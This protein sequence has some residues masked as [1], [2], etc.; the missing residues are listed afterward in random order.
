[1]DGAHLLYERSDASIKAVCG[2][3]GLTY[4]LVEKSDELKWHVWRDEMLPDVSGEP[5][6]CR[7]INHLK[8]VPEELRDD[9]QRTPFAWQVQAGQDT[10]RGTGPLNPGLWRCRPGKAPEKIRDGWYGEIIVTPNGKWAVASRT[11]PESSWATPNPVVRINLITNE[12]FTVNIPA[13]DNFDPVAYIP[14]YDNVLLVRGSDVNSKNSNSQESIQ[15]EF[16]L[17]DAETGITKVMNGNFTP[18][19]HQTY[20]PLQRTL[21]KDE[22]WAAIPDYVMNCT[23]VGFYNIEKFE[24]KPLVEY[25]DITFDSSDMWVER[26]SG[27]VLLAFRGDLLSLPLPQTNRGH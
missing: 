27:A 11:M 4:V 12:E 9:L 15:P 2:D 25:P 8:D 13:A 10:I 21:N 14:S 23:S 5:G 20:R 18:W 1:V 26:S 22:V 17:L 16:Y 3:Q 7:I 19:L 6:R 24:F